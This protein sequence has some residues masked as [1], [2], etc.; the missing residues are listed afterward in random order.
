MSLVDLLLEK[1][2]RGWAL[3]LPHHD[4]SFHKVGK[5]ILRT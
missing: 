3:A 2:Q 4:D 1:L 5:K